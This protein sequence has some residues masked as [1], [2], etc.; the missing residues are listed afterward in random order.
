MDVD[1][2]PG[3]GTALVSVR[4][5][6]WPTARAEVGHRFVGVRAADRPGPGHRLRLR[7]QRDRLLGAS[8]AAG[9]LGLGA[10]GPRLSPPPQVLAVSIGRPPSVGGVAGAVGPACGTLGDDRAGGARP[11]PGG[12]VPGAHGADPEPGSALSRHPASGDRQ[13]AGRVGGRR[14]RLDPA[15]SRGGGPAS[16]LGRHRT[17]H[18]GRGACVALVVSATCC[19]RSRQHDVTGGVALRLCRSVAG[20]ELRRRRS[21]GRQSSKQSEG[22]SRGSRREP[23]HWTSSQASLLVSPSSRRC[24]ST[25]LACGMRQQQLRAVGHHQRDQSRRRPRTAPTSRWPTRV[26]RSTAAP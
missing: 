26:N 2:A 19:S 4:S 9:R 3:A 13:P 8:L 22:E 24:R 10:A 20:G 7:R 23:V 18:R 11:Q 5:C 14:R 1:P 6:S 12:D 16:R 15:I 21:S 25:L 17:G